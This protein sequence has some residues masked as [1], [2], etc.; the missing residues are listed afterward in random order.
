MTDG[1][2]GVDDAASVADTRVTFG[3]VL[4]AVWVF[5]RRRPTVVVPFLLAGVV[6]A[7]VDVMRVAGPVPTT[8]QTAAQYGPL[9][10]VF[11]AVPA[12][13]SAVGT[14]PG[15]WLGLE[16]SW[17]AVTGGLEL[18]TAGCGVVAAVWVLRR[19]GDALG[20]GDA[21][22]STWP[23]A[24]RLFGYQLAVSGVLAGGSVLVGGGLGLFGL[25]VVLLV[26]YVAARTFLVPARVVA[27]D[28]VLA[29][30]EWSWART[31]GH[32]RT[33]AGVAVALGVAANLLVSLPA[34]LAPSLAA[35]GEAGSVLATTVVG[36]AHAVG[37][38]LVAARLDDSGGE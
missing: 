29:S 33:L 32:A 30:V 35:A 22:V 14:S 8:G 12:P 20:H 5:V 18:L 6:T 23:A 28:G 21:T 11:H 1:T 19:V 26:L 25:P 7:L 9:R 2:A 3:G 36:T 34:L 4:R 37:V 15:A 31:H 24:G 13:V 38:G 10:I 17:L 16:L 27:G